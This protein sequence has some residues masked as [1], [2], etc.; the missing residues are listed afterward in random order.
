MKNILIVII[1]LLSCNNV[2]NN[3]DLSSYFKNNKFYKNFKDTIK[4]D[5][6]SYLDDGSKIFKIDTTDAF[7]SYFNYIENKDLVNYYKART[8]NTLS[9]NRSISADAFISRYS[10]YN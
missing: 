8:D 10:Y 7:F 9:L 5:M 1:L 6:L 2:Q 4:T 3:N